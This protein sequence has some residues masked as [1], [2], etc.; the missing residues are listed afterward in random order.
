MLILSLTSDWNWP[1]GCWFLSSDILQCSNSLIPCFISVLIIR[2]SDSLLA[3]IN[4]YSDIIKPRVAT[5]WCVGCVC[6]G[7]LTLKGASVVCVLLS[8]QKKV[9]ETTEIEWGLF[10]K[11]KKLPL[12]WQVAFDVFI[13]MHSTLIWLLLIRKSL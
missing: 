5:S 9:K 7:T 8:E 2:P 3:N 11:Q 6:A 12:A 13:S 10:T 1:Q 4:D